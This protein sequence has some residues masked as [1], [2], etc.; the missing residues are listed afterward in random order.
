[1]Q[2]RHQQNFSDVPTGIGE[3]LDFLRQQCTVQ[4][5]AFVIGE[6][7]FGN[8]RATDLIGPGRSRSGAPE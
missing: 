3:M 5:I 6:P 7:L 8:L 4:N 2:T 1:M